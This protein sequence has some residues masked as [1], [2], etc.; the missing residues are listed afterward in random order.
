MADGRAYL[1]TRKSLSYYTQKKWHG[2][3]TQ[4]LT[5]P[6]TSRLLDR[7]G[8]VGRFNEKQLILTMLKETQ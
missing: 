5:D 7:I 3:G 4:K 1:I 8:P 6:R 2:K